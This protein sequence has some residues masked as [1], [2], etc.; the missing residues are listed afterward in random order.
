[1]CESKTLRGEYWIHD[2]PEKPD[3]RKEAFE[4]DPFGTIVVKYYPHSPCG[5]NL[6]Y[7]G[8]R[9]MFQII[10]NTNKDVSGSDSWNIPPQAVAHYS[11]WASRVQISSIDLVQILILLLR[12]QIFYR[13]KKDSYFVYRYYHIIAATYISQSIMYDQP[14]AKHAW[15][16]ALAGWMI[17]DDRYPNTVDYIFGKEESYKRLV[18][19][20]FD[21]LELIDYDIYYNE[22]QFNEISDFTKYKS[23]VEKLK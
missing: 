4:Y 16:D 17:K 23:L 7:T 5:Y 20:V 2:D 12:T 6:F 11:A 22:D 3:N 8:V 18:N 9:Y 14:L 21:M 15:H 1:M 19:H 10:S 13:E